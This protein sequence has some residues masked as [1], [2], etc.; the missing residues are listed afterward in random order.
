[1]PQ[2]DE[3]L[4]LEALVPDADWAEPIRAYLKEWNLE[5]LTIKLNPQQ[6]RTL[7][8]E[9]RHLGLDHLPLELYIVISA[10]QTAEKNLKR[11]KEDQ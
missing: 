6:R 8:A 1:M 9:M 2:N 11:W 4:P 10:V 5:S 7:E 3:Q